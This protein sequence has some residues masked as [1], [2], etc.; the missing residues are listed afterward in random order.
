MRTEA[1]DNIGLIGAKPLAMTS[2]N[3]LAFIEQRQH[4]SFCELR[5]YFEDFDGECD[6]GDIDNNVFYW[7]N[8]SE[9]LCNILRSLIDAGQIHGN[10]T[11]ILVYMADGG[12]LRLPIAKRI[13]FKY[14]NPR[15]LPIVWN[16][17]DGK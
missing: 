8:I 16:P 4:V 17:G 9:K 13:G 7:V 2:D 11:T 1:V 12:G 10:P 14:K 6:W 3:I 15:W 5:T